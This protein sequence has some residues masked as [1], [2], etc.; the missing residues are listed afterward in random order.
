MHKRRKDTCRRAGR[1]GRQGGRKTGRA[2]RQ[3]IAVNVTENAA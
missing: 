2:G 1:A 3:A